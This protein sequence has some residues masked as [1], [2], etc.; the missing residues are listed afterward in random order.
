MTQIEEEEAPVAE[1]S[2][3]WSS[4]FRNALFGCCVGSITGASLGFMDGMRQV[5]TSPSLK[6]LSGKARVKHTLKCSTTSGIAFCAF[7]GAFHVGKYAMR[8]AFDSSDFTQITVSSIMSLGALGY[9]PS[10]RSLLPYGVAL[11]AMDT[12]NLL[13]RDEGENKGLRP[14]GSRAGEKSNR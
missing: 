10:N 12:F 11:V 2:F 5:Q 9:K 7:F 4:L 13:W 14:D 8:T 1:G 6:V 3:D